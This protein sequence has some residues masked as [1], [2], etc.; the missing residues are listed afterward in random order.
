MYTGDFKFD[1]TAAP[2]YRTDMDRL[3]EI[4][5]KGVLALLSDSSNAEASFPSA[6]EQEIGQTI[7]STA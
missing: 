1:P 2:D 5:Q 3:A 4:E 7:V 6:S